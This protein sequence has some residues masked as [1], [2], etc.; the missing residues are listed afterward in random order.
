MKNTYSVHKGKLCVETICKTQILSKLLGVFPKL[1]VTMHACAVLET[2]TKC[3]GR[4][5]A[6]FH[7]VLHL[8]GFNNMLVKQTQQR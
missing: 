5:G 4:H 2:T 6:Y 3:V 8:Q 1:S 7:W